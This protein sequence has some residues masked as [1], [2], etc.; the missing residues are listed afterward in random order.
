MKL[1]VCT[2]ADT[3]TC[4]LASIFDINVW[5]EKGLIFLAAFKD[6]LVNG[7][8]RWVPELGS[9]REY[10]QRNRNEILR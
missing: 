6:G 5:D 8:A 3:L 10:M 4:L 1:R 2:F 9:N 7:S